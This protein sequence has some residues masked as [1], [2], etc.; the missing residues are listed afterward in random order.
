LQL[1]WGGY[2]WSFN[3]VGVMQDSKVTWN[4]GGQALATDKTF[5]VEGYIYGDTQAQVTAAMLVLQKAL[6]VQNQTLVLLQ[7]N[8]AP[9]A[10][11]LSPAGSLTGVQVHAGPS[12]PRYQGP[13][14]VNQRWFTAT[15]FATYPAPTSANMLWD[16]HESIEQWGGGPLYVSRDA[17]NGDGQVQLVCEAT[18]FHATQQGEAIGYRTYP[19]AAPPLFPNNFLSPPRIGRRSPKRRSIGNFTEY[20]VTWQYEFASPA[21]TPLSVTPIIPHFWQSVMPNYWA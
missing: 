10:T 19:V 4:R 21:S 16:F 12:Y 2:T 17:T 13:E 3:A 11:I 9:S 8:G 1:K 7:D 20:P 5:G 14:Y 15:F 6:S 18:N